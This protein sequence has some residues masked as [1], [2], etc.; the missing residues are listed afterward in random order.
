MI[1]QVNKIRLGL[2]EA[3]IGRVFLEM[4][5]KVTTMP[6]QTMKAVA[7]EM[8]KKAGEAEELENAKQIVQDSAILDKSGAPFTLSNNPKILKAARHE[9]QHGIGRKIPVGP[10]GVPSGEIV[11]VPFFRGHK[12]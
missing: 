11:G 10:N 12:P 7:R 3:D 1:D 4:P 9:A 8:L 2:V 6:W 5:N